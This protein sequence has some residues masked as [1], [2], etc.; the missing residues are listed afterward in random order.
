[1]SQESRLQALAQRIAAVI[2]QR[3]VP[4]GGAVGQLLR[5]AGASDYATGWTD[6]PNVLG[7]AD[8]KNPTA[9]PGGRAFN[10]SVTIGSI[11]PTPAGRSGMREIGNIC[12]DPT[13]LVTPYRLYYSAYVGTYSETAQIEVFMATSA[14]GVTW[15]PG[16][17]PIITARYIEDPYVVLTPQGWELYGEDKTQQPQKNIRMFRSANGKDGWTDLGFAGVPVSNVGSAWNGQDVSSPVVWMEGS[18]RY[19][20]FEARTV[21]QDGC[22]G[23]AYYDGTD[24][25]QPWTLANSGQPVAIGNNA[26]FFGARAPTVKWS[27]LLVPDD[28]VRVGGVYY[29]LAHGQ[30]MANRWVPVLLASTT[31]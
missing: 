12:Y 2:K 22:I 20:L 6:A 9:Q 30:S 18:R 19:C 29:L 7:W 17:T 11:I 24:P 28:L 15:T 13:D 1:M 25:T 21:G 4:A 16:T 10:R 14:N 27:K 5:K 8:L 31:S 26:T 3:G 23:L